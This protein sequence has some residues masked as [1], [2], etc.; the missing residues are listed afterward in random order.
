MKPDAAEADP[1][2]RDP[3]VTR[4]ARI[5]LA[6]TCEP[7]EPGL[8][9]VLETSGPT[10]T[11]ARLLRQASTGCA[12]PSIPRSQA[13]GLRLADL[14]LDGL[15]ERGRMLGVRVILPGDAEW[16]ARLSDLGPRR[17]IALWC[18]GEANVRLHSLR[19]VAIVGARAC[20][21]YGEF[22]ARDWAAQLADSG[23][24]V[25]SGGAYGID[26]AAHRGALAANG[27]T[28]CL[29]AGGV[30]V[31]YP[32]GHEGLFAEIIERGVLVSEVP[33]GESVRRRRFLTRNRLIG[34][35]ASA[36]CVVEASHRSGS[37]STAGHAADLN[38]PVLAVPGPVT[39]E[40]SRGTHRLI[41]DRLAMLA[42]DVDDVR[43]AIDP[44]DVSSPPTTDSGESRHQIPDSMRAVLDV[45]P[46]RR[47]GVPGLSVSETAVRSGTSQ[48]CARQVLSAALQLGIAE[49]VSGDLWLYRPNE[50]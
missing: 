22:I 16:P 46:T 43:A 36:T 31:A 3:E 23:I 15:L 27:V 37:V 14:D 28:V 20:T 21:R 25:I 13:I 48:A 35:L 9:D 8:A 7:G 32:R 1:D 44:L 33:L 5:A 38:R 19:S 17:P 42:A 30:D 41:A 26:A 11:V 4:R 45:L 6:A 12:M 34:A 18:W 24:A 39:S 40:T 2:C 47:S 29:V 10:A 49:R 50:S